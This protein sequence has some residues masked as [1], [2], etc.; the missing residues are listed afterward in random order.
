MAR[1]PV[2]DNPFVQGVL[3]SWDYAF[4]GKVAAVD[5][6]LSV[7]RKVG[8]MVE[9]GDEILREVRDLALAGVDRELCPKCF[10][11][12]VPQKEGVGEK[13]PD[14]PII[15]SAKLSPK[16]VK[17]LK[18]E[19]HNLFVAASKA[20]SCLDGMQRELDKAFETLGLEKMKEPESEEKPERRGEGEEGEVYFVCRW[21]GGRWEES[22]VLK[23]GNRV[24]YGSGWVASLE[25]REGE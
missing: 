1:N 22:K 4:R 15:Q 23:G 9:E 2:L 19:L 6:L 8:P 3:K 7:V 11:E 13:R 25:K 12:V 24:V 18:K 5:A 20:D 21:C 14:E 16:T 10:R 17:I